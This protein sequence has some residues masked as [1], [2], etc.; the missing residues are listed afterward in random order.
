MTITASPGDRVELPADAA[1]PDTRFANEDLLPVPLANRTW[2]TYNFT[3]LWI[4]M[5]HNIPSWTL[6]SGL[7]ALGMDWKQAVFTIALANVIVLFPMLLTGHAGPRYGIPFPVLARA[8][9]GLRGANLPALV[10]AAVACA[11]FGIQTWIGGQGIFV[12][13]GKIFG[14][15]W[16]DVGKIGGYP[17]TMWLCF[18]VFWALELAIIYR[19]MDTL[20]RFENWAAPFVL[21][22]AVVLLIWIT[23]KAGGLGPLLDQPSK[24]GW[25]SDFWPVF[26]PSLMGMI[27]FWSTLSLNIPDFTRFGAGQRAQI[28]GQSLGLPTTMTF[29]ALLSVLVTSGSQAVYGAAIWNPVE[30]AAKTDNV[31]GLVFALVTVLIATISVNIA[32]NVVSPAYDLSNLAPKYINFRTGAMITGVVGVVIFP[33]KLIETPEFYIFT[34]LGVVGG[35]LGTVAGIL[36]ADY[37]II[38]RTV[39]D[40]VDLY[41][42]GGRYWYTAGWN[43]RAVAAFVVGGVLAVGGSHSEPGKGPFPADGMIPFLKPLA[44]Y[45][46]AV[47][48]GSALVLYTAL[49]H[50]LLRRTVRQDAAPV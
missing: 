50:P 36:I 4:G 31:F 37:W 8:S 34:W 22:G 11:W 16:A 41:T 35:L 38:R 24:L 40:L 44:D 49:M 7:V 6:A 12:L 39:L 42:P 10:R 9:F 29:F 27:G 21:V 25:G 47:G 2:T 26:F 13:L 33:W 15:G 23:V 17:W 43:W 48:L 14:G 28:W 46:W 5:A 30:L 20:R 45:G 19:G 32:A 1:L 3:A 18:V